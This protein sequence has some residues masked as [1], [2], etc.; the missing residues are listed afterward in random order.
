MKLDVE[1]VMIVE[2]LGRGVK[3]RILIRRVLG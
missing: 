2:V 3:T 1:V